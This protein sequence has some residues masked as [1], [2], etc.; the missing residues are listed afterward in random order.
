MLRISAG[1]DA[2]DLAV[3]AG[4]DPAAYRQAEAGDPAGLTYLDIV[5]LADALAVPPASLLG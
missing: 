5:A 2:T 1:L 3:A 4:L